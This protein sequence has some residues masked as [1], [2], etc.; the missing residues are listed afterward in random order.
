[1]KSLA[2]FLKGFPVIGLT[3]IWGWRTET[4]NVELLAEGDRLSDE[5]TL[6][7]ELQRDWADKKI[8]LVYDSDIS[9][10]HKAYDAFP[11]LAEQFYRLGAAEVRIV[12]LPSV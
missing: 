8:T 6:L 10:G 9:P 7:P 2:G 11:R 3:G 1:M 4:E 5:E 12:T